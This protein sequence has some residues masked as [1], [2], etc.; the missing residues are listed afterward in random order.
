MIYG[1]DILLDLSSRLLDKDKASSSHWDYYHKFLE[2]NDD[3]SVQNSLGFGDGK[4]DYS[5]F[6][7]PFHKLLQYQYYKTLQKTPFFDQVLLF[8]RE[9]SA[10]TSSRFS[11]DSLRQVLTLAYLQQKSLIKKNHT[12]LVIG[13]GFGTMTS[14]LTQTKV[15]E[16]VVLVNLT[17][18][19]FVDA[20]NLLALPELQERKSLALVSTESEMNTAVKDNKINVILVEAKHCEILHASK[21]DLVFNIV[22][23]QEMDMLFIEKYYQQ[24]RKVAKF[25]PVFFYCCNR[26]K[27]EL[28]DASVIEFEHYPWNSKDQHYFDELCPWHQY[29]YRLLPPF[30]FPYDGPIRHRFTKLSP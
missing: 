23:M 11:L 29:Y 14:L 22:S 12:A 21:A 25:K 9:N 6:T 16:K 19:L 5:V 18:T 1:K 8:G 30:F 2:V 28:P 13:D 4:K 26:A 10:R 24:M 3:N 15:A 7:K 20:A 27:K 17:K